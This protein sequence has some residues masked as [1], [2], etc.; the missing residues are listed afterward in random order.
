MELI[1]G[2]NKDEEGP[3]PFMK[4]NATFLHF[5]IVQVIA[6][7]TSIFS[8]AWEI[9]TGYLAFAGFLLFSYAL[10]VSIAAAFAILRLAKWY[11]EFIGNIDK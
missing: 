10:S 4:I 8:L 6:L 1:A 5:I 11:D 7:L 9:R 2:D 3:S